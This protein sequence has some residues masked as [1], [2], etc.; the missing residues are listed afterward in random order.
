MERVAP[1]PTTSAGSTLTIGSD[2]LFAYASS[3]VAGAAQTTLAAQLGQIPA[4][5]PVTVTGHT[6]S[7]GGDPVASETN[8]Q[9]MAKNRRVEL[10]WTS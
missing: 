5:V 8:E 4:G 6:D 1:P 7:R 3:V 10:A 9:A 2:V